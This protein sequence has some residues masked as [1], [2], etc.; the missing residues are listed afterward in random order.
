MGM[1]SCRPTTG[2]EVLAHADEPGPDETSSSTVRDGKCSAQISVQLS[3]QTGRLER[4]LV[5]EYMSHRAEL[6]AA[7]EQAPLTCDPEVLVDEVGVPDHEAVARKDAPRI[8]SARSGCETA[9]NV[10]T[11]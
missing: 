11:W 10:W 3:V 8:S 7:D 1:A 6:P 9:R 5:A 4:S 2:S